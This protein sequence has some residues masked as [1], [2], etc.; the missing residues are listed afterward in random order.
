[1]STNTRNERRKVVLWRR[2]LRQRSSYIRYWEGEL[3]GQGKGEETSNSTV[4]E[5]SSQIGFDSK[6]HI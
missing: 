5:E 6:L 3:S 1:M 4:G 2:D